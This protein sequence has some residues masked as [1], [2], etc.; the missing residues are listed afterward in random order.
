V[1]GG[2]RGMA[3]ASSAVGV[4]GGNVRGVHMST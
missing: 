2:W 4:G 3:V 1:D